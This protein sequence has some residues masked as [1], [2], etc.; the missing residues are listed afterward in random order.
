MSTIIHSVGLGRPLTGA[1]YDSNNDAL[2]TDKVETSTLTALPS[3]SIT[4]TQITHWDTAYGWGDHASGGY[5][6]SSA[7]GSTVQAYAANLTSWAAIAPSA[8]QDALVSGTNIKTINSQSILG[9]GDITISGGSGSGE[10]FHPFLLC[11]A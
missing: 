2:N 8:K 7:I 5:L 11:G 3:Y 1:E 9:S 6:T 10:S 4:S